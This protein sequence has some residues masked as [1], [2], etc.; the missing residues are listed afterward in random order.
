MG[1]YAKKTL[2]G[3]KKVDGGAADQ[4][5]EYY[6]ETK[7]EHE[8]TLQRLRDA[9]ESAHYARESVQK[10]KKRAAKEA[11]RADSA[12][13]QIR[14]YAAQAKSDAEKR[15]RKAE[16]AVAEKEER[17]SSLEEEIE[18]L[19]KQLQNERHL[20]RN[21]KRIM[22]ERAN[23]ARGITPKKAHDGYIVLESR[24]WTERYTEDH[25]DTEDHRE[26]YGDPE[27]R[28]QAIKKGYLRKTRKTAEA[29][30]SVIQ[31]P[32][33]SSLPI[34]QVEGRIEKEIEAVLED[35]NVET[36][37]KTEYNGVYYDFGINDEGYEKNGLYR[38]K[39]RANYRS[40][41]WEMEIYTTKSLRVPENRRP[42]Q[43]NAKQ[44]QGSRK[45]TAAEERY[46][47]DTGLDQTWYPDVSDFFDLD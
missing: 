37:L 32:Y 15:V 18:E 33:D 23:Q 35:I 11:E 3:Y 9:Q 30:K 12:E 29:W 26:R 8:E 4:D 5:A 21:M 38:W 17:I 25:W 44:R 16:A 47:D 14:Q 43:R 13:R 42:P 31:T 27:N 1:F 39:Y 46:M 7:E 19:K 28:A 20:Y 24:Q 40:G 22:R 45:K 10:E 36:R 34:K 2:T 41:L 6:I